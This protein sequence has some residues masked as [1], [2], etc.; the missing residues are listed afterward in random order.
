MAPRRTLAFT[1]AVLTLASACIGGDD[2]PSNAELLAEIE[3]RLLTPA[4]IAEREER[5]DVLCGL[6]DD[7]LIK[8]WEQLETTQ[9]EFQDFVFGR[10]CQERNQLYAD[11]TG[12]F[13]FEGDVTTTTTTITR[14]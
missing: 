11:A 5:A 3:G 14:G 13:R 1:L 8:I 9:L 6:D 4:E 7:V 2:E 12:R 10:H